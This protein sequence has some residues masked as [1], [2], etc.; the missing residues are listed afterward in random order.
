LVTIPL[1]DFD[2]EFFMEEGLSCDGKVLAVVI[3][4]AKPDPATPLLS[5]TLDSGETVRGDVWYR[6][7]YCYVGMRG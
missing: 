7:R 4:A 3:V 1:I 2:M 6:S 5:F